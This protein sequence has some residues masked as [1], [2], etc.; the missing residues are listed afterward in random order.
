MASVRYPY[1]AVE[2]A[3]PFIKGMETVESVAGIILD[4]ALKELWM[5]APWRW[6]LGTLEV[7]T[8]VANTQDVSLVSTYTDL[9]YLVH[10]YITDGVGANRS[11]EVVPSLPLDTNL[12]GQPSQVAFVA[13]TPQKLRFFPV[14]PP[15]LQTTKVVSLYKKVCPSIQRTYMYVPGQ[16]VFDDEW[17]HVYCDLVLY[18]M[19]KFA[20]DQRAG[21]VTM[22]ANGPQYTGQLAVYKA[23]V[24]EMKQRE[25]LP[26]W[27]NRSLVERPVTEK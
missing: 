10:S 7:V 14:P 25:K 19:Y 16:Q 13:G 1:E 12:K 18:Y 11:L 6:T 17:F 5:E 8:L 22:T 2:F 9:L 20:D 24:W 21:G 26:F 15:M 3:K 27:D 4:S 23:K